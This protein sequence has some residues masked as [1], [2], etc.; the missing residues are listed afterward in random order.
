MK[1]YTIDVNNRRGRKIELPEDW[2][3]I[4]EADRLTLLMDLE[5]MV[6]GMITPV[7]WQMKALLLICSY[8]PDWRLLS[9]GN[10]RSIIDENLVRL[11]EKIDF[12]FS[13]K[14]TP[15]GPTYVTIRTD[16]FRGCP[17][18]R[19]TVMLHIMPSINRRD[20]V[21]GIAELNETTP[22]THYDPE[23]FKGEAIDT[24]LAAGQF[25]DMCDCLDVLDK[26]AQG[27]IKGNY[28]YWLRRLAGVLYRIELPN[29]IS[30]MAKLP[31]RMLPAEEAILWGIQ[32]WA[33]GIIEFFAQSDRYGVLFE[34]R[35]S[36]GVADGEP[37][38]RTTSF[39]GITLLQEKGY[40]HAEYLPLEQY[41]DLQ[42]KMLA[43]ELRGALSEK[44]TVSELAV[45]TGIS[46]NHINALL[47]V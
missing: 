18:R 2:L 20:N 19:D 32:L 9:N 47:G 27:K 33:R 26:I 38:H 4:R 22:F 29:S 43:D 6:K 5:R 7:D 15:G 28:R 24:N 14:A 35:N 30:T 42:L 13:E 45:R 8:R 39:S 41:L 3:E 40:Q 44:V 12:A 46:A 1:I 37:T 21:H 23:F 16:S 11:S 31:P 36:E 17:F 10:L 25:V 34:G